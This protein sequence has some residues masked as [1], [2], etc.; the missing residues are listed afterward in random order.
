MKTNSQC[1]MI[2]N[3]YAKSHQALQ[4][5]IKVKKSKFNLLNKNRKRSSP[6][7]NPYNRMNLK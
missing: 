1:L 6:P 7:K 3:K 2:P 5:L 4:P